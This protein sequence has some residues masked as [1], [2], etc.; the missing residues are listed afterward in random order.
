MRQ[1][2]ANRIILYH[3][4]TCGVMKNTG[5][6]HPERQ[7]YGDTP[8]SAIRHMADIIVERFSPVS[9]TLFGSRARGDAD[10]RSDVDL[11][12]SIFGSA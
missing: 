5:R 4:I 9:V 11:E 7:A 2:P 6:W 12:A 8:E 10:K 3:E 1:S